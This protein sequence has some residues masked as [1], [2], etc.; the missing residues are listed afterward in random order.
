[1]NGPPPSSCWRPLL[2]QV[3]Y[4]DGGVH[5]MLRALILFCV[6]G[7]PAMA[8]IIGGSV[9]PPFSI[10][11]IS[12]SLRLCKFAYTRLDGRIDEGRLTNSPFPRV[13]C[14]RG[15]R[16]SECSIASKGRKRESK[17][18]CQRGDAMPSILTPLREQNELFASKVATWRAIY[19][20]TVSAVHRED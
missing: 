8:S 4:V 9:V 6:S 18:K 7:T 3:A 16:T 14:L 12:S 1:M 11:D 20:A 19:D 13:A 17:E 15:T 10:Q 5:K 2:A